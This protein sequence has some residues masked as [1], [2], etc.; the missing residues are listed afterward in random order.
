M[1][2]CDKEPCK[3]LVDLYWAAAI[4]GSQAAQMT[5]A[6]C[7]A[8]DR[9]WVSAMRL[10]T[11]AAMAIRKTRSTI[12]FQAPNALLVSGDLCK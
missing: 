9:V 8:C 12:E 5:R 11:V 4:S 10:S 6:M 7:D 3:S 1:A 2:A